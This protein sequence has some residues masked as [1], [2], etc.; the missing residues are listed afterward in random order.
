VLKIPRNTRSYA[1]WLRLTTNGDVL[2]CFERLG[3]FP[4]IDITQART[5]TW[6]VQ[7]L[8]EKAIHGLHLPGQGDLRVVSTAQNGGD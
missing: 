2:L 6:V 1:S 8:N 7:R 3:F 4:S 5:N